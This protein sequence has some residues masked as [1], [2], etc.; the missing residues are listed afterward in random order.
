M[1]YVACSSL[2][3]NWPLGLS[4]RFYHVWNGALAW[5][6]EGTAATPTIFAPADVV[7]LVSVYDADGNEKTTR[8]YESN[9]DGGVE[10]NCPAKLA[11]RAAVEVQLSERAESGDY[12]EV[13]A[14]LGAGLQGV[15]PNVSLGN[16]FEWKGKRIDPAAEAERQWREVAED[17]ELRDVPKVRINPP[18]LGSLDAFLSQS[19][20]PIREQMAAYLASD[21]GRRQVDSLVH[22]TFAKLWQVRPLALLA[23]DRP[24]QVHIELRDVRCD[25]QQLPEDTLRSILSARG[26]AAGASAGDG[27]LAQRARAA[28]EQQP[29][30]EPLPGR[31]VCVFDGEERELGEGVRTFELARATPGTP[32]LNVLWRTREHGDLPISGFPRLVRVRDSEA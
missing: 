22:V 4:R 10:A 12:V 31:F 30:A 2:A 23:G 18:G 16:V 27:G 28:F 8:M 6:A 3:G 26:G 24:M 32:S 20:K 14:S 15:D 5:A 13:L 19:L 17:P 25:F 21:D 11:M 29:L 7:L 1:P 9:V